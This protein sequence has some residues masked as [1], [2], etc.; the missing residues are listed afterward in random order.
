MPILS[1][2]QLYVSTNIVTSN[3]G[4][5]LFLAKIQC[6][7]WKMHDIRVIGKRILVNIHTKE[8]IICAL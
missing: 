7:E 6:K 4:I 3:K 1:V 5:E 2:M 8:I